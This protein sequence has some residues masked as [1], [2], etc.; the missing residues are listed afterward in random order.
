MTT[1]SSKQQASTQRDDQALMLLRGDELLVV[2]EPVVLHP[3]RITRFRCTMFSQGL[4][5][6]RSGF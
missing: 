2:K 3:V 6:R 1:D 4:V 5:L